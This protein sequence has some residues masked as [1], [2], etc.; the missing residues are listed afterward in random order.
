VCEL[1]DDAAL[2]ERLGSS[3]RAR[4]EQDFDLKRHCLPAQLGWVSSV[5]AAS[6]NA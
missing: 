5:M 3:A 2:R 1:L 6:H 4:V